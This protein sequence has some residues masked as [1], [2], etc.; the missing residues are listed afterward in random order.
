LEGL[1][2]AGKNQKGDKSVTLNT[3]TK[4]PKTTSEFITSEIP[5]PNTSE[6]NLHNSNEASVPNINENQFPNL[7]N[8]S[9]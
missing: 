3:I 5:F 4:N 9:D 7:S 1:E 8:I 2:D 6:F